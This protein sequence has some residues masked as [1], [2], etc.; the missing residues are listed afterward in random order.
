MFSHRPPAKPRPSL[1]R[2]RPIATA[3]ALILQSL[4]LEKPSLS[5]GF[6]AEPSQHITSLFCNGPHPICKC[7]GVD[8]YIKA[9]KCRRNHEG[10]IILSTGAFIPRDIP[11]NNFRE[12]ID[13][14]YLRNPGQLA[15]A[16]L[17]HTI[18]T[19]ILYNNEKAQDIYQLSSKDG[20]ANL[21]AEL[22]SLRARN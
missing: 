15:A 18:D 12:R 9:G 7:A 5:R 13:E 21:E 6:Q 17:I 8:Q 10:R 2:P 14:W 16:S 19:R 4:S 11:G 3:Q 22:F 1:S 20:V